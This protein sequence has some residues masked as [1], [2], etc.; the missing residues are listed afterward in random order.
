MALGAD[1]VRSARQGGERDQAVVQRMQDDQGVR[2]HDDVDVDAEPREGTASRHLGFRVQPTLG[3]HHAELPTYPC[4]VDHGCGWH[5]LDVDPARLALCPDGVPKGI[6]VTSGLLDEDD[7]HLGVRYTV[8][9]RI[10]L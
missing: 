1:G 2:R 3:E 7:E 5:S 8:S 4:E 9:V 10:L 6:V